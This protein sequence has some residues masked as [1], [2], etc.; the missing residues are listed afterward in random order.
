MD[1]YKI[2]KITAAL[3]RKNVTLPCPRCASKNF[4]VVGESEIAITRPPLPLSIAA[5][6]AS[7]PSSPVKTTM[8][9]VIITCDNC[10]YISQ[11]AQAALDLLSPVPHIKGIGDL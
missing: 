7:L 2:R 10:G 5:P 6:I 8:P 9:T 11:H 4:S 3:N 1:I